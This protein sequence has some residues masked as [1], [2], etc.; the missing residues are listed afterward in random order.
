MRECAIMNRDTRVGTLTWAREG[1]YWHFDAIL[2]PYAGLRRLEIADAAGHTLRLG[3]PVPEGRRM[4]LRRTISGTQ[5]LW[6]SFRLDGALSAML[7]PYSPEPSA[8]ASVSFPPEDVRPAPDT[9][10][11]EYP[12][13]AN[14]P[15]RGLYYRSSPRTLIEPFEPQKPL[16][17]APWYQQLRMEMIGGRRCLVLRF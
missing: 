1:L 8:T 17:L 12:A 13:F 4:R 3:I 2:D 11:R 16:A 14:C 5:L 15:T 6:E 9:L 10:S 7:H